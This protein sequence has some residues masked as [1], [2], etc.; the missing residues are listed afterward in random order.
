MDK[1]PPTVH[2]GF[3]KSAELTLGRGA[4]SGTAE[5]S[6]SA[7]T[8]TLLCSWSTTHEPESMELHCSSLQRAPWTRA[9]LV[10]KE[11]IACSVWEWGT[12]VLAGVSKEDKSLKE[13]QA[14][15][16][17]VLFQTL[18]LSGDDTEVDKRAS[19]RNFSV[20]RKW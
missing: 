19:N 20:N 13:N 6:S 16:T 17:L 14:K 2:H 7:G 8:E 15:D 9:S 1:D 4:D 18:V 3:I 10:I 5:C 12:Q 11:R